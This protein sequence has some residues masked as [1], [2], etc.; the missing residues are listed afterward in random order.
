MARDRETHITQDIPVRVLSADSVTGLHEP[1]CRDPDVHIV[2]PPLAQLKSV[3]DRF[4]KLAL[5]ASSDPFSTNPN[6]AAL[7]A[8]K[9]P[10]LELAGSMHGELRLSLAGSGVAGIQALQSVW[11]NLANPELDPAAVEG[12]APGVA[13]HPS[14][15]MREM[16][17][18][19][20][21][22]WAKVRIDARDWGKV[23]SVGRLAGSRVIAC[24]V[25]GEALILYVYLDGGVQGEG[26]GEGSV[27]TVS[28][29]ARSIDGVVC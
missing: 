24:F 7:P 29:E 18:D 28:I 23:M 16:A 5:S 22:R 10:K 2:L 6:A 4:T 20:P 8:A 25:G 3:S 11:R 9:Q 17:A 19:D 27:L 13:E 1:R 12:G 15:R 21:R 14:T 26:D